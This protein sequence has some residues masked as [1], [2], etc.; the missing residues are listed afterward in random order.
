ML[1]YTGISFD[2]IVFVAFIGLHW[3]FGFIGF[4][5]FIGLFGLV[6]IEKYALLSSSYISRTKKFI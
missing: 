5:G 1:K 2:L 3:F 6:G 4:V